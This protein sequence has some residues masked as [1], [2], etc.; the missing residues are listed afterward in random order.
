M[1]CS[2]EFVHRLSP[3]PPVE[4]IIS[5]TLSFLPRN[6]S[7]GREREWVRLI[8]YSCSIPWPSRHWAILGVG[9][10]CAITFWERY[11]RSLPATNY[12]QRLLRSL[13]SL[14]MTPTTSLY[15]V[16]ASRIIL[17]I[18]SQWQVIMV[19]NSDIWCHCEPYGDEAIYLSYFTI[20][21]F[22]Y[23]LTCCL[24]VL[25]YLFCLLL[26]WDNKLLILD[27]R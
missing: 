19:Y 15:I 25:P 4:I 20:N 11:N 17:R 1:P 24:C 23:F 7:V 26:G 16:S 2:T 22:L 14:A 8:F 27:R 6:G 18:R 3:Q 21:Y 10:G 5:L 13:P 12:F 9:N